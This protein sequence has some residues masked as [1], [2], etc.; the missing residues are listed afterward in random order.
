MD[1]PQINFT[2]LEPEKRSNKVKGKVVILIEAFVIII[3]FYTYLVNSHLFSVFLP[4]L[5]SKNGN[6]IAIRKEFPQSPLNQLLSVSN[7]SPLWSYQFGKYDPPKD[8]SMNSYKREDPGGEKKLGDLT[9]YKE[10]VY[11]IG[12]D[13]RVRA[14]NIVTGREAWVTPQKNG[15]AYKN[16]LFNKDRMIVLA[17]KANEE[18]KITESFL[19]RMDPRT[20]AVLWEKGLEGDTFNSSLQ[21][22]GN[23]IYI[24]QQENLSLEQ[25]TARTNSTHDFTL[26]PKISCSSYDDGSKKWESPLTENTQK[27][28]PIDYVNIFSFGSKIVASKYMLYNTLQLEAFDK[29]NG[30]KQWNYE[31]TEAQTYNSQVIQGTNNLL[32]QLASQFISLNIDSGVTVKQVSFKNATG[33][34]SDLNSFS[35]LDGDVLY[36]ISGNTQRNK[37]ENPEG[38]NLDTPDLSAFNL[39]NEKKL[40]SISIGKGGVWPTPIYIT[41][42][43]IYVI[44]ADNKLYSVDRETGKIN[45]KVSVPASNI[46]SI[47]MDKDTLVTHDL[48]IHAFKL[49]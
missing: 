29:Q 15:Y 17:E 27:Y 8:Y 44:G 45:W 6:K 21:L 48:D 1:R 20:G 32:I 40:W 11:V 38:K 35:K 46:E 10:N 14:L 13:S 31:S 39:K 22:D 9:P 7:I 5:Q 49:Q 30:S 28:Q 12:I 43:I 26:H 3:L 47:Y 2:P 41:Q 33:L 18:K 23:C 42:D 19:I 37:Q 25:Y 36:T 4:K 16:F 34:P 24:A